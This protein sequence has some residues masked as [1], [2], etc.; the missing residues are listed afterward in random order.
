MRIGILSDSHGDAK[1][2]RKAIALLERHGATKFF[3]CGDIGGESVLDELV[4][5][6]CIFVWGNCDYPDASTRVYLKRVGLPSPTGPQRLTIAGKQIAVC[7]GHEKGVNELLAD[8]SL[9]YLFHG[10]TH[11]MKDERQGCV[12][13]INPGAL[14]RAQV[15]TVALLDLAT[16]GLSFFEVETGD[17]LQS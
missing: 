3:H 16:D 12:R 14:Y 8:T 13:V 11:M 7:H 2:T 9:D 4:G 5:H 1:I 17:L 6:D 15:H 10:H